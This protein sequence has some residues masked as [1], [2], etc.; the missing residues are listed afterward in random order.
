VRTIESS[1]VT[2]E[3]AKPSYAN[4]TVGRVGF[5]IRGTFTGRR[6]AQGTLRLVGRFYR[7]ERQW[8]A[9]DSMD[10]PWAVGP[11]ASARLPEI[12]IGRQIGSYYPAVPSL[13]VGVSPERQRFIGLVDGVC[14]Q[15]YGA[16]VQAAQAANRRYGYFD[17]RRFLNFRYYV[18]LHA[19]QLQNLLSL[20]EP[21][22]ARALYDAWRANFRRRVAVEGRVLALYRN[23]DP[24]A[25][26]RLDRSVG[27]L[28]TQGN[29][30][31]QR[32]GLVRCT[33]NGDRTPVPILSDGQPLALP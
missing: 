13:A 16:M 31:G 26:Y 32:F 33:S 6:T 11:G 29:E 15:T 20:G 21:P 19:W 5:A 8:N 24:K 27:T 14:V 23:N 10:V 17:N 25:G 22:Q 30:L 9:C 4:G 28:K 12:P 3:L 18:T 2:S 1:F 7:G